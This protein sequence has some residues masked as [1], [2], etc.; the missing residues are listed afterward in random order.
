MSNTKVSIGKKYGMLTPLRIAGRSKGGLL[1]YECLC[2]CGNIKNIGSRYLTEGK[3]VS[4]GCKRARSLC[5]GNSPTYKSWIS[6]KQRCYNPNNHNYPNYGG[7]GIKMCD[8]WIESFVAFLEDMGERP[9]KEHTLD[10]I[11][12]NGDYEP[13][14]CRWATHHTQSNNR[15]DNVFLDVNNERLTVSEFSVKYN[16]NRSSVAYELKRGLSVNEIIEKYS[17]MELLLYKRKK[18]CI[19]NL[20]KVKHKRNGEPIT[21]REVEE[22]EETER[23]M[24]GIGSSG[25]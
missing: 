7:R 11:D 24:K 17:N 12:V 23:G 25:K 16:I 3:T 18:S 9:S 13:S 8:R 15:R 10:R 22:F 19:N 1:M 4:C 5:M 14:N 20:K 2:D 21:F 6:A